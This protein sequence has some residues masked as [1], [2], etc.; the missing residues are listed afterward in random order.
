MF[1]LRLDLIDFVIAG[2]S[3]STEEAFKVLN[4]NVA[5][6]GNDRKSASISTV[7]NVDTFSIGGTFSQGPPTICGTNTGEHSEDDIFHI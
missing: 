4:G 6:K 5:I 2:P 3:T 1:Q 7:C